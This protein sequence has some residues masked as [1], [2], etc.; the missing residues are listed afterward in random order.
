MIGEWQG[1]GTNPEFLR[2]K[3]NFFLTSKNSL[4]Y[5]ESFRNSFELTIRAAFGFVGK[6]REAA[7]KD[8]S[9]GALVVQAG[10]SAQGASIAGFDSL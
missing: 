5:F 2:R 4:R 10:L 8:V 6:N 9:L 1:C 3:V 7:H